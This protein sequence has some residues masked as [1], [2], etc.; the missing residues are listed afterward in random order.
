MQKSKTRKEKQQDQ[1]HPAG[2]VNGTVLNYVPLTNHHHVT[3]KPGKTMKHQSDD[4][5]DASPGRNGTYIP[6][7]MK[8]TIS[9]E[10]EEEEYI[11]NERHIDEEMHEAYSPPY[12]KSPRQLAA[13]EPGAM[14]LMS[15]HEEDENEDGGGDKEHLDHYPS[16]NYSP[17]FRSNSHKKWNKFDQCDTSSTSRCD[18]SDDADQQTPLQCTDSP[19]ESNDALS[20]IEHQV[21]M[22]PPSHSPQLHR[23]TVGYSSEEEANSR[24]QSRKKTSPNSD[25]PGRSTNDL[26]KTNHLKTSQGKF[27]TMYFAQ[28]R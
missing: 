23:Q 22:E 5:E 17:D 9:R 6:G 14:L 20:D 27:D 4:D 26:R 3:Y 19:Y 15:D 1:Y 24:Y 10:D 16:L 21:D 18:D 25:K 12:A 8:E 13:Y 7:V 28:I 2:N 11:N